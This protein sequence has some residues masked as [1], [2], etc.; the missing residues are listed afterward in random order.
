[1][2]A[3]EQIQRDQQADAPI[4]GSPSFDALFGMASAMFEGWAHHH[5][6]A[7]SSPK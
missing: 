3:N 1:L 5:F 6:A 2:E 7:R 4:N